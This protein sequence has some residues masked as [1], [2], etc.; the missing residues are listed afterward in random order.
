MNS[1]LVIFPPAIE[2]VRRRVVVMVCRIQPADERQQPPSLFS[3]CQVSTCSAVYQED[4]VVQRVADP[5][6]EPLSKLK[7]EGSRGANTQTI[8]DPVMYQETLGSYSFVLGV[9]GCFELDAQDCG[10]SDSPDEEDLQRP[11]NLDAKIFN[12]QKVL[13]HLL[14]SL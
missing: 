3:T 2:T 13:M 12:G 1:L 9:E 14:I 11:D 8:F 7:L 6:G 5:A 10:Q 4:L